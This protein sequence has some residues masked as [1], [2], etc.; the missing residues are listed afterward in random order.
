MD[1][2]SVII[3]LGYTHVDPQDAATAASSVLM[4]LCTTLNITA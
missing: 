2:E 4:P 3:S 1:V